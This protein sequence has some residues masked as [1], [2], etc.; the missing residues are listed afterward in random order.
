MEDRSNLDG[1]LLFAA[2]TLPPLLI[3]KPE[4]VSDLATMG[5]EDLTIGPAHR[6]YFIDANLLIAKVLNRIYES[7]GVCHELNIP[8]WGKLGKYII[9]NRVGILDTLKGV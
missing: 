4:D 6:R 9:T 7:G 8:R 5:A 2:P 1:E 3:G